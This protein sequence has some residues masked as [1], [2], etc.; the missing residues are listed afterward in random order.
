MEVVQRL[1]KTEAGGHA[2][3]VLCR[4]LEVAPSSYY[5]S[6]QR[7]PS[8]RAQANQA[9]VDEL[10]R[11]FVASHETYGS[12][13]LTAALRA[14]GY[15]VN[16]KRVERLM[17]QEGMLPHPV[18]RYRAVRQRP[19]ERRTAPNRLGQHF[20]AEA[21]NQVW[22]VDTT[23]FATQEGS[24][25]LAVVEDL[26][27]RR[28]VGW[29]TGSHF[30]QQL[31]CAALRRALRLRGGAHQTLHGLLHHSDQGAQYTSDLYLALLAEAGLLASMS[32][33]GNC[34][35]NAPIESFIATLKVEWTHPFTYASRR[36]LHH[37]LFDFIEGFYNVRRLHSTLGY[38]SPVAFERRYYQQSHRSEQAA[39]PPAS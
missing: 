27:S 1:H 31:V 4:L 17:R 2:V 38:L 36:Q 33:A 6:L 7:T 29:V 35:D 18:R 37:D 23:E 19:A 14:A 20:V 22:L 12:R 32:A 8:P 13:R 3:S 9:L 5:H 34:Y 16:H 10:R 15:G 21:P 28:V 39:S 26:F 30:T 24:L 25:Y 11:R